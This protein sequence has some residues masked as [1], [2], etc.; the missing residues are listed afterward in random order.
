MLRHKNSTFL[1]AIS[2]LR[3]PRTC[4]PFHGTMDTDDLPPV[5]LESICASYAPSAAMARLLFIADKARDRSA[6]SQSGETH[7]AGSQN[8][9]DQVVFQTLELDA[10]KLAHDILKRGE[11]MTTYVEVCTRIAG[12]DAGAAG[13]DAGAQYTIDQ[14]LVD[15]K[16]QNSH[17]KREILQTELAGYKTNSIKE[18]IRMGYCDLGDFYRARGDYQNAFK[19]YARTRDYCTTARH[20]VSTCL[21][22]AR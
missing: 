16:E 6:V 13:T 17:Q 14:T 1:S 2:D 9:N 18:S 10:L 5:D 15:Q 20:V 19:A 7:N 12:T 11:N 22:V 21:N 3:C 4:L 8:N